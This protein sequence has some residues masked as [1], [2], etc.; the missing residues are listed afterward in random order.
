[1]N[2][3][4]FRT[5]LVSQGYDNGTINSRISNCQRVDN[6]EGDLDRFYE[7]DRCD[8]LIERL[9]Y[10]TSDARANLPPR[11]SIPMTGNIRNGTATLKQSVKLYIRFKDDTTSDPISISAIQTEVVVEPASPVVE[12]AV[13]VSNQSLDSYAQFLEY[14]NIDK[15]D[16][17]S[18]G[19]E[20]T[21]FA[22]VEQAEA[23]WSV[24]K[25]S[26]LTNGRMSIRSY[27][28]QGRN[29]ELFKK[30]YVYL[31]ANSNIQID[32]SNNTAAR[33][34]LQRV[35]GHRLRS[36]LINYQCSHIFGC[37]K[38]P[39]LFEA[40]W[41]ICF[42]P[43]MFDPL[44]GHEAKGPWPVEYQIK[45]RNLLLSR[46]SFL[47]SDYNAFVEDHNIEDRIGAFVASIAD[48]YDADLLAD[49]KRDALAEWQEI[50]L[51]EEDVE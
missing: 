44:T 6:H 14:F 48:E 40:V 37:T 19:L 20:N 21:I 24:L 29:S 9:T 39:L 18:F 15:D 50:S 38:N 31:F 51:G 47:I 45:L 3:E 5:W 43:K 36:T 17:Y 32:P 35:T 8:A 28:R 33:N 4:S 13:A 22:N 16:F 49:F 23:Q 1:M 10:S 27:G 2:V 26:L 41:N 42:T 7:I 12:V 11:H 46:F 34:N 25:N 30:L